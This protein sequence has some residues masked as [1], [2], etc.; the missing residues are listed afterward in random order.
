MKKV[1]SCGLILTDGVKILAVKP[2]YKKYDIPKGLISENEFPIDA[3]IRE[4][5]EETG[6]ILDKSKLIDCGRHEYL[7]YKDLHV[8]LQIVNSNELPE[9][10]DLRC[11]SYY[12]D[13]LTG[14]K[15]PENIGYAY[16]KN[17]EIFE[18]FNINMCKVLVK[19]FSI[20]I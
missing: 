11:D 2:N 18:Y 20:D 7:K 17:T 9:L 14:K 16:I 1:L 15:K 4:V 12:I 10:N 5:R 8:F 6:L 13:K 3:C 19:I